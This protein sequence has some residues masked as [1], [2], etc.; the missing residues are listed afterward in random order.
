MVS[1]ASKGVGVEC[2]LI[3]RAILWGGMA[4]VS[5]FIF[6]RFGFLGRVGILLARR[7]LFLGACAYEIIRGFVVE[8][9]VWW[10]GSGCAVD[11]GAVQ[12]DAGFLG[13]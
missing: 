8:V 6:I 11:R 2:S 10:G 12:E 3:H 9:G 4:G 5:T 7:G 13:G 1:E